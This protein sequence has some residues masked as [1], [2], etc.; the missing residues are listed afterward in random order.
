MA[1]APGGMSKYADPEWRAALAGFAL[2]LYGV[3][4]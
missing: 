3:V 4:F 1:I 2:F